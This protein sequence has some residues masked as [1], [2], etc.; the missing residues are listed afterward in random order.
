MTF[1]TMD[2]NSSSV[3]S[4][5]GNGASLMSEGLY[6]VHG[7]LSWASESREWLGNLCKFV[8]VAWAAYIMNES[9]T[10][11][12]CEKK[13]RKNIHTHCQSHISLS[14]QWTGIS[15][16][17]DTKFLLHKEGNPVIKVFSPFDLV[18]M[19]DAKLP[20]EYFALI[21]QIKNIL[22]INAF[23]LSYSPCIWHSLQN[24]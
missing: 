15:H 20:P 3:Y 24:Q 17:A 21:P 7:I 2:W 5:V 22:H 19:Y 13:K 10:C 18:L 4:R 9:M 23:I 12:S 11:W 8:I 14:I 1:L 16:F 6:W